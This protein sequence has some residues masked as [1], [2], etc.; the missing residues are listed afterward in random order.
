MKQN[1]QLITFVLSILATI[2]LIYF[3]YGAGYKN[4]QK[5][6]GALTMMMN[7]DSNVVTTGIYESL[8]NNVK[9]TMQFSVEGSPT[10]VSDVKLFAEI[11]YITVGGE[12]INV[13]NGNIW[14]YIKREAVFQRQLKLNDDGNTDVEKEKKIKGSNL[15]FTKI[16]K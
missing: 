7:I 3:S 4:S 16:I 1:K 14:K 6:L 5:D 15:A 2:A 11:K 12:A 9:R 10:I 8:P 13:S